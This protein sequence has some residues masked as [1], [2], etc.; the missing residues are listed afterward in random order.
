MF[1]YGI[2]I[3]YRKL[4]T[5]TPCPP[6][7]APRPLPAA[8]CPPPPAPS[9]KKVTGKNSH[10]KIGGEPFFPLSFLTLLARQAK[11]KRGT[12][13]S[14][15][16][17]GTCS[18]LHVHASR[19]ITTDCYINYIWP[20]LWCKRNTVKPWVSEHWARKSVHLGEVSVFNKRG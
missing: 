20:S 1:L 16:P 3:N 6:P 19:C 7:P 2:S 15:R 12:A 13:R 8:P 17:S 4:S 5:F 14:L 18:N 9:K 10:I 11:G